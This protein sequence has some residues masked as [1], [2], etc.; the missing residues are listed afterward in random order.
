MGCRGCRGEE[1][2]YELAAKPVRVRQAP[3]TIVQ[4]FIWSDIAPNAAKALAGVLGRWDGTP[5]R[6][7]ARLRGQGVDCVNL[8]A[9]VYDALILPEHPTVLPKAP[10]DGALHGR[11][12]TALI[13]ALRLAV[14]AHDAEDGTIEPGDTLLVAATPQGRTGGH[15]MLAGVRPGSVFHASQRT[16][17]CYTGLGTRTI[18]RVYRPAMKTYWGM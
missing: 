6:P 3:Q 18:L 10:L 13:R 9:A 7:H 17:A 4:G 2:F 12:A 1:D 15:V 8:L 14:D 11:Q 5:Y 16:G